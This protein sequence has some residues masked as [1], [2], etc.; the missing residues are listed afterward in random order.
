M[1]LNYIGLRDFDFTEFPK[2]RKNKEGISKLLA[3]IVD[4][5]KRYEQLP[6]IAKQFCTNS[7]VPLMT[8]KFVFNVNV[9]ES[10]GT[11]T[12]NG[13]Q[14]VLDDYRINKETSNG[15]TERESVKENDRLVTINVY[16]ALKRFFE[17]H[18]EMENSGKLTVPLICEIHGILMNG[19]HEDAGKMRKGIAYAMCDD[20]DHV[21]PDPRVAEQ[22]F[23]AC[24]DHH[25]IQMSYYCK[26]LTKK[27]PSVESFGYLFKCAAQ[28]LF[29]FVDAHPFGDGNGRMCRLLANHV[30]SLITPFPV[31]P[32]SSGE[33]R[34]RREDYLDAIIECRSHREKGPA[35]L[36]AMLI[37]GTWRGWK[38]LFDNLEK[39]NLLTSINPI[40]PVVVSKSDNVQYRNEKIVEVFRRFDIEDKLHASMLQHV[41][42][43]IEE[44]NDASENVASRKTV[45][46][47][48]NIDLYLHIYK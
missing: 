20:G 14:A 2:W 23:E 25:S 33:G 9:G 42:T 5:F 41:N 21:Y 7:F 1:A 43:V 30:L 19:L 44:V 16:E 22:L 18:K 28:L 10:V 32:Y 26:E 4:F 3:E 40:G 15:S 45:Q 12:E 38:N 24:I 31:S 36:A 27:A 47:S 39:N 17:L 6:Q 29:D 8:V 35:T 48:E 34:S 13:T 11:Q 37:E 46:L